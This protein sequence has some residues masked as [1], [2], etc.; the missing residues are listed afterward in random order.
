MPIIDKEGY[1]FVFEARACNTCPGKCCTGRS[2][3][4][5]ATVEEIEAMAE[6]LG[7][8]FAVFATRYTYRE[9]CSGNRLNAIAKS[10]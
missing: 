3:Y 6:S 8:S 10:E 2:G 1:P 7:V 4:I 5:W 9:N